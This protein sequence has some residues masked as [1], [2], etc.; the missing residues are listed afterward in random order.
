MT[1]TVG[2]AREGGWLAFADGGR[3]LAVASDDQAFVDAAW[4]ALR[5][6]TGLGAVLDVLTGR[7]LTATPSFVLADWGGDPRVIVRGD[8]AVTVGDDAGERVLSAAGAATW[9]EQHVPGATGLRVTIPGAVEA[10]AP[11]LP[12]ESGVALAAV[13]ACGPAAA[14]R[15][16]PDSAAAA[17]RAPTPAAAVPGATVRPEPDAVAAAEP[18]A[19][20]DAGR[21]VERTLAALPEQ[22]APE[23]LQ[24]AEHGYDYLFGA[25]VMRSVSDAA[26]H[27]PD[28]DEPDAEPAA[29]AGDHDGS[30]VLTTDIAKLRGRRKPGGRAAASTTEAAQRLAVVVSST[31]AREPLDQPLLVGRSPSVSQVP[32]GK[33]P[34]LLIVDNDDHDISRNHAQV[35]LE[36]GTP[37]VTDLHSRNG[38]TIVLPGKAP[39]KL[40]AG[41]PTTVLVGTVID[42]GG[43]LTLTI[44]E[45]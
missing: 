7:G 30:T 17:T 42:L 29:V 9:V 28:P 23:Q 2:A 31:G 21:A 14:V 16:E 41:E 3:L 38:T 37:V 34:R 35:A 27:T 19:V 24:D 11:A 25:T 44:E 26:V 8:A 40:R 15:S 20:A 6:G 13:V 39:Q 33:L 12:L 36:G 18:A 43:G 5:E 10:D 45:A 4:A 32:G 22:D 1:F